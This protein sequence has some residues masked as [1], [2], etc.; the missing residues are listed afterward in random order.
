MKAPRSCE[1]GGSGVEKKQEKK[2]KK[3]TRKRKKTSPYPRADAPVFA[4]RHHGGQ[5]VAVLLG[6]RFQELFIHLDAHL[7]ES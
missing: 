1:A 3:K 6:A 4:V 2:K 5:V 7:D